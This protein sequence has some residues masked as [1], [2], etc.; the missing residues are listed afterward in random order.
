MADGGA[1]IAQCGVD[2]RQGP[3]QLGDAGVLRE[4]VFQV[5]P[6]L[7]GATGQAQRD[8]VAAGDVGVSGVAFELFGIGGEGLA[9]PPPSD[10][11]IGEA[12]A[13]QRPVGCELRRRREILSA[14]SKSPWRSSS[15][16]SAL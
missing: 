13:G 10:R 2:L 12:E 11:R 4:P 14:S 5:N 16:P 9:G 15:F 3:V 8:P 6:R 1:V 7:G